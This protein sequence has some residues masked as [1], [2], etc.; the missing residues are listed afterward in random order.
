[1]STKQHPTTITQDASAADP[2]DPPAATNPTDENADTASVRQGVDTSDVVDEADSAYGDD[3][4]S[5]TASLAT[6]ILN[7]RKIH[8][9]TFHGDVGNAEYW[10]ANDEGQNE[11]LD[12]I[13][14][15]L[16]LQLDGELCKAPIKNNI[17]KV[18]DV[19]TG[20]G[21]WAI[22]F[23]DKHPS[24]EVIGIDVSPIQPA[25]VPPNVRFEIDDVTQPWTFQPDTFDFI[26]IRWLFGSIKDWDALF[27]EA[28]R[29][30]KPGGWIE[31]HEASAQFQSDDGSVN[32]N[33]A[34][35]QFGKFFIDG[36]LKMGRSMTVVE[37]GV[38]R[39][40]IEKAGFVNVH[41][42]DYKSPF[43]AWPEGAR[44][45][46]IGMFQ[47]LAT[48][49]DV[50]GSMLYMGTLLG[51]KPEEVQ[52]F[53]AKLRREFRSKEMKAYYMQKIVWAQKPLG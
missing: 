29:A 25:W 1:M 13:H 7:Y 51:W 37:D 53:A 35:G 20:T 30:L 36:G 18:L 44:E 23:G 4:A 9:R 10:G 50:D 5:S 38:Q 45:R 49:R 24:A 8:G 28:F 46:E 12:I 14:H 21:L 15:V 17:H 22:D 41:E 32:E 34:M 33:T 11:S 42:W 6:S 40:G 27:A 16:T 2:G 31:S 52:V 26:H 39:S 48:S 19:G 43:G 3:A 47:H